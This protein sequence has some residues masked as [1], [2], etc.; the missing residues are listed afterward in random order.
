MK[1]A[2]VR[3][4]AG[5]AGEVRLRYRA[6]LDRLGPGFDGQDAITDFDGLYCVLEGT[7]SVA[8]AQAQARALTELVAEAAT[9]WTS[10]GVGGRACWC[11]MSSRRCRGG[12]R[13]MS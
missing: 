7:A 4:A 12:C 3:A 13:C 6:L 5:H 11:W 10:G 1:A 8:V 2:E 9:S